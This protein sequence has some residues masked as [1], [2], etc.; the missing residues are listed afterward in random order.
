MNPL[1]LILSILGGLLG[2]ILLLILFGSVK[3]R[4]VCMD[5]FQ[6]FHAD[7]R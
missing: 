6:R 7:F 1:L 5:R 4:I 2:L 3:I